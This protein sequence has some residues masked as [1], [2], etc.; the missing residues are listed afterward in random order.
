MI[1]QSTQRKFEELKT[2][3]SLNRLQILDLLRQGETCVC[4]IVSATG[5]KHNLVSHHLK[6]LSDLNYVA[7]QKEGLHNLYH[8]KPDKKQNINQLFKYIQAYE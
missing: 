3:V 4:E 6:V 8:L 2:L 5:L 1:D 7:S